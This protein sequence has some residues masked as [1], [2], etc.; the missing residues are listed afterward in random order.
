VSIGV[1]L[2]QCTV[3]G[4]DRCQDLV[5]VQVVESVQL[6]PDGPRTVP[7]CE[8]HAV[9]CLLDDS[10]TNVLPLPGR[11]DEFAVVLQRAGRVEPAY[12]AVS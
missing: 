10:D 11:E 5:V 7:A 6:H 4:R 8:D 1:A 12:S 2:G 3:A 9:G